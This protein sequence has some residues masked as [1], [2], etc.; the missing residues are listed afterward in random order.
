MNTRVS[1]TELFSREEIK[2]LTEPSDIH[3]LWAVGSTWA[4]IGATFAGVGLTWSYLPWWGKLLIC[5]AALAVLAGRQLALAILMHDASH[6][7][8]FKTKWMNDYLVDWL[9]ARPIW[10]DVHKYRAHHTRHHAKTSTPED[11]DLTLVAGFPTTKT[12]LTRKFLRDLVG[13]TGFKFTVGRILMDA[14]VLKWTVANDLTW[15]PRENRQWYDYPKV[16]LKNSSKAIIANAS[17]FGILWAF[18]RSELYLLWPLAYL[19]PFPLF[20]RIRSMAEHAGTQV[21]NSALTNTR[22]TKAGWLARAFVA[23]IRVNYH[24]EHHLM[25]AVPFFKLPKMHQMLRERGHVPEPPTYAQ[26]IHMLSNRQTN[27]HPLNS[28][29]QGE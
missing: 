6:N 20:I 15:L 22:T 16:F 19:T 27:Q 21:S 5:L 18:G 9:C 7:S 12:S 13:I 17:I 8:L 26:V 25:A 28:V 14:E 4:I 10:N 2:E 24:M 23:P 29:E 1:V 11:P 3:G